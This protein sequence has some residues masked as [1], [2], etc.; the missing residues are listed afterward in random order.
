MLSLCTWSTSFSQ[1]YIIIIIVSKQS[2]CFFV[3]TCSGI[4]VG[5]NDFGDRAKWGFD[6][7][8]D[9]R[10]GHGHGT[11]VAGE[12]SSI[13]GTHIISWAAEMV[14]LVWH[15]PYHFYGA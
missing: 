2:I 15:S 1:V 14:W 3:S 6:V 9:Y 4:Y 11:H 13:N 7:Y 8:E 10:D 5:H 12:L